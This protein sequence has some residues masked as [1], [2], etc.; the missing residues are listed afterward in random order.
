MSLLVLVGLGWLC[1]PVSLHISLEHVIE[2]FLNSFLEVLSANI[3][4]L[5]Q[6]QVS[7]F[8]EMALKET[9]SPSNPYQIMSSL[10]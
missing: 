2:F 10:M 8:L 4:M 6:R 3:S 9:V 5:T 7:Y 1:I